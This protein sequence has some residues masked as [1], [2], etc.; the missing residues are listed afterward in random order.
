MGWNFI[1]YPLK[2]RKKKSC[3][4][5]SWTNPTCWDEDLQD[6]CLIW[7]ENKS[8]RVD[9]WSCENRGWIFHMFYIC[10]GK[11]SASQSYCTYPPRR[12]QFPIG[13]EEQIKA[14][15]QKDHRQR[16]VDVGPFIRILLMCFLVDLV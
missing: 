10:N 15:Q 16:L 6:W 7:Y 1:F 8:M 9:P 12:R 13:K 4:P 11:F 2:E 3:V 5:H 14:W